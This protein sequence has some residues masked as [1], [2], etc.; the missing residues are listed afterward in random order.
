M[1]NNLAIVLWW[2]HTLG[3]H[4]SLLNSIKRCKTEIVLHNVTLS[5]SRLVKKKKKKRKH[6]K[7]HVSETVLVSRCP[8]FTEKVHFF[9]IKC[10]C[11]G[12]CSSLHL[13]A[14]TNDNKKEPACCW[15]P[16]FEI[17]E[18][19]MLALSPD[20]LIMRDL[21]DFSSLILRSGLETRDPYPRSLCPFEGWRKYRC[22]QTRVSGGWRPGSKRAGQ[23]TQAKLKISM[24]G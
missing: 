3:I 13:Q 19:Q 22:K 14:G 8:V 16:Q 4:I 18:Q 11:I 1:T 7:K 5:G 9:V 2:S 20:S 24:S 15:T 17:S 21:S 6:A 23:F 10:K 12:L